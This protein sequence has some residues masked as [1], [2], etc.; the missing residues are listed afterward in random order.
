MIKSY[1]VPTEFDGAR[2]RDFLRAQ[3]YSQTMMSR[4]KREG[5]LTVN[6]DG[7]RNIDPVRA[8]DTILIDFPDKDPVLTPNGKVGS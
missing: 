7:H 3:G 6:G 1:V 2:L 4:M 8:G 5:G